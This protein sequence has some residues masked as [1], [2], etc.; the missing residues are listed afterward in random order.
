MDYTGVG[1]LADWA[2]TRNNLGNALFVL[3]ERAGGTAQ[4][5]EAVG[6]YRDA[7][8]EWPRERAPVEWA[9]TQ[10]NIGNAL[11]RLG[12]RTGG[13]A[14][15]EEA[16]AAYRDAL[17]ELNPELMPLDW[18]L[19]SGNQGIVMI[20]LSQRTKS[21]TMAETAC[22]QIEKALETVRNR[23]YEEFATSYA[24]H[25]SKARRIRDALRDAP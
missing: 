12:E 9:R 11:S 6:A 1:M 22:R 17:M 15:L 2:R 21:V 25:L 18:A 14:Q 19:S 10:N 24:E 3:G 13:T 8:M 7:L 4:L 5:E 20:V 16:V 23:G